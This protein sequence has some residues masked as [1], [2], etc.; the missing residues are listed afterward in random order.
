MEPFKLLMHL[1]QLLQDQ[2]R[3]IQLGEVKQH[4]FDLVFAADENAA[5]GCT[6]LV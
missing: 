2:V 6:W 5:L 1:T 4:G 3:A